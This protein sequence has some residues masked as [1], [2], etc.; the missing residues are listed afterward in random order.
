[1][2]YHTHRGRVLLVDD[3]PIVLST[4][5][6]G[7]REANYIVA[8][9]STAAEAL[10]T[11]IDSTPD[12]AIVD[13]G[14]PDMRGTALAQ[15]LLQHQYRPILILSGHSEPE[16]VNQAIGSGVIGYLVKPITAQQLI[17]S[18][19]TALARFGEINQ[20]I[21]NNFGD[22]AMTDRQ[23][24]SAMDEFSFGIIIVDKDHHIVYANRFARELIASGGVL[25]KQNGKLRSRTKANEFRTMLDKSLSYTESS[26]LAAITL[27]NPSTELGLQVLGRALPA[28]SEDSEQSAIM[29]VFDPSQATIVPSTLLENLYGFTRKESELAHGLANGLT[30]NEYC[31]QTF[32]SSNTARTHLKS[33][34]RKT[35]TNR[36]SELIRLLSH[37]FIN[38]ERSLGQN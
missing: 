26:P 28:L 9:C 2:I 24:A 11:Y 23:L 4:V 1:M 25:T 20:R 14:L 22:E 10:A 15:S 16:W 3:D 13:I 19:E 32:I 37:L 7:L 35:A 31:E 17:P 29:A 5:S 8:Q 12:L 34:Y 6:H 38:I 27:P 18:I 36:Q 33:I 21:A 30:I